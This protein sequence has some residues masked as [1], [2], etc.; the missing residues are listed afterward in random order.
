[1]LLLYVVAPASE[2]CVCLFF[3]F[4]G[5]ESS[6]WQQTGGRYTQ[7]PLSVTLQRRTT[8]TRFPL[9]PTRRLL[10][11]LVPLPPTR[12]SFSTSHPGTST[13]T[14]LRQCNSIPPRPSLHP[15]SSLPQNTYKLH[16]TTTPSFNNY[17]EDTEVVY[18]VIRVRNVRRQH[19][20]IPGHDVPPRPRSDGLLLQL[21]HCKM[22]Y[23]VSVLLYPSKC[24]RP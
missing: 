12:A 22:Y 3:S 2:G 7:R 4:L 5:G 10:H 16:V 9:H 23:F 14:T 13:P 24:K 15:P 20:T 17:H 19:Q 18:G 1:M 21:F 11:S 6:L 8:N